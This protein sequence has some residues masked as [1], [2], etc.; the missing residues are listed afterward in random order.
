MGVKPMLAFSGTAWED[1]SKSDYGLAKSMFVDF[2]RGA[3]T[4]EVDVEGL[5]MLIN[6]SIAEEGDKVFK[7][8]IQMRCYKIVTKRSGSQV[9]K[10]E[11][12]EMGPRIDFKVGRYR[13]A[14]KEVMKQAMKR[15]RVMEVSALQPQTTGSRRVLTMSY[16]L[17]RKKM[18]RRILW[19]IRW[20][21]YIWANRTLANC[22]RG[23]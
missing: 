4:S 1:P 11:V 18:S 5:Q 15:S 19:G 2:F 6:F 20:V 3:E 9:P 8:V 7:P 17:N 21:E 16:R 23:R 22:K 13:E 14:E 10:V 12:E